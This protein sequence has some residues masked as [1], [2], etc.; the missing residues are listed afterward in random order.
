[1]SARGFFDESWLDAFHPGAILKIEGLMD[2][3]QTILL[4]DDS[5]ND[6]ILMRLAFER[7]EFKNPLQ[8]ARNGEEALV[9]LSGE[10]V[11]HDRAKYPWPGLVLLDLNMPK[12]N[13]FDVLKWMRGHSLLKRMPVIVLTASV[14]VED[15]EMA[16]D[17]G[18][19]A[20]LVKPASMEQLV[21]MCRSLRDWLQYNHFPFFDANLARQP[22][23]RGG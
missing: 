8:V 9:Y 17:L 10:G 14:R 12:K 1:M 7:A 11:Y 22:F 18:A 2:T 20:F 13:G 3:T 21:A 23:R 5:E 19:N 4:V 6:L 16:Y 15:V